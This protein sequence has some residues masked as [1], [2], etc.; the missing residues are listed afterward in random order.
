[1][2]RCTRGLQTVL[3]D[4]RCADALA[5][6]HKPSIGF[7]DA[8]MHSRAP[9][10][11]MASRILDLSTLSLNRRVTGNSAA[12]TTRVDQRTRWVLPL[13]WI[14]SWR[15]RVDETTLPCDHCP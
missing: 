9:N 3:Q 11:S 4:F 12:A 5:D 8:P 6:P 1:M 2:H 7:F 13:V 10:R 14:S 15:C